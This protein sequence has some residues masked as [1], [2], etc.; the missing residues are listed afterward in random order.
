MSYDATKAIIAGLNKLE[1]RTRE[2]LREALNDKDFSAPGASS[3][4]K[5]LPTKDRDLK[6]ILVK[7]GKTHTGYTFVPIVLPVEGV[8]RN[9]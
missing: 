5:F 6:P 2:G 9:P 4:V 7:V 3:P 8:L 1:L